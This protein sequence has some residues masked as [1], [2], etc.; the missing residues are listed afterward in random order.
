MSTQNESRIPVWLDAP[1]HSS[2]DYPSRVIVRT[3]HFSAGPKPLHCSRGARQSRGALREQNARRLAP[4]ENSPLST[5][6]HLFASVL[7]VVS[8]LGLTE[9]PG[10]GQSSGTTPDGG[11]AGGAPDAGDAGNVPKADLT[12]GK[13]G[14]PVP[15]LTSDEVARFTAGRKAF[16]KLQT[17]GTGLGPV[18]NEP[19]CSDCHD[20]PPAIG[21]TN[22]HFETRFGRREPD[23]GFDTLASLGGP[24]LH[25]NAIGR[26]DG[27]YTF[28]P[29]V[30]PSEATVITSRRTQPLFG[31]GLVDV[32]PDSVFVALAETQALSAPEAAGRTATVIDLSTGQPA[33]GKFGWKAADAT[34]FDFSGDAA[35]NEVGITSPHFPNE[36][37]PQGDCS[38]LAFNPDPGLNDPDGQKVASFTDFMRF[39]GPPPAP[40]LVDEVAQGSQVFEALGCAVCHVPTLVTGPNAVVA[41]DQVAYHPYSD[42]LLHDMGTL[43]DGIDQGDANGN[44]MRTQPLWGLSFQGRM[45]H[46]GRATTL[47]DAITAHEGQGAAA[48]DS[49]HALDAADQASLLA[50][51]TAL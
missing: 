47:T 48:R 1:F 31:L 11:D 37:C 10:C 15:G 6:K 3:A 24:L 5:R 39:L 40:Q 38:A 26:V 7:F 27:G 44:E 29:E 50:F 4:L 21:G 18:F 23:G 34:L 46:D 32:T 36:V 19:F 25:D 51:L 16:I 30:V 43:G 22:Q 28:V 45:L 33:V 8:V 9:F 17:I 35:L 14:E 13:Y 42:F 20:S 2:G 41:F 12:N 49:F